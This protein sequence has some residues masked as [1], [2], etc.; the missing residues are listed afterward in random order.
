MV[1]GVSNICETVQKILFGDTWISVLLVPQSQLWGQRGTFPLLQETWMSLPSFATGR[2]VSLMVS[3]APTSLTSLG[4]DLW[5]WWQEDVSCSL[6]VACS[7]VRK[8][9][10]CGPSTVMWPD[11]DGESE[12]GALPSRTVFCIQALT[13]AFLVKKATLC[14]FLVFV[15]LQATSESHRPSHQDGPKQ[16]LP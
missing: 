11:T 16:N 4:R 8:N 1:K 5:H 6:S 10:R 3:P 12:A 2:V 15:T 13:G 9:M 7:H 14:S